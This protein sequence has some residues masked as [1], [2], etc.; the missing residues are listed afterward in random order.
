[1]ALGKWE[2]ISVRYESGD[3]MDCV[4]YPRYKRFNQPKTRNKKYRVTREIQVKL[5]Q[6]NAEMKFTRLVHS[7]FTPADI[8]F[9][10]T[11]GVDRN[12]VERVRKD[13]KAFVRKVRTLHRKL[14]LEK[15]KYVYCTE[16]GDNGRV[17]I[18]MIM[19]G[20]IERDTLETIWKQCGGGYANAD[21]LQFEN[22]G[23]RGL[24]NYMVKRRDF[25]RRWT[26]SRN[27]IKP[28]PIEQ[29]I[30]HKEVIQAVKAAQSSNP[31]EH[32]EELYKE[33]ELTVLPEIYTSELLQLK[34]VR[35]DMRRKA[36]CVKTKKTHRKADL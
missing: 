21:R 24:C 13:I 26:P 36:L 30:T 11:Y 4:L 18:H 9:H 1:M 17:H 6:R 3:Y 23:L 14:S 5:N 33:W 31:H 7:N 34:Y 19:S 15:L 10:A 8:A 25:Y 29:R 16:I 32:F 27:L 35:F 2:Y 22:D 20:G 28:E 12:D